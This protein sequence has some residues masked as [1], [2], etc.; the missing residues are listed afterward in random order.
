M[1]SFL[2]RAGIEYR[3]VEVPR[4]S[5][6]REA[7]ENLGIELSRI[8]KTVVLVSEQ[9][10]ALLVV[11][12][13]DRRVDQAKLARLLGCKKLRLATDSEVIE[14]TGYPP[15]GVPPVGHLRKLPVY[16][17]E[18]LLGGYYYVGG[19]DS[20]HL[21][22]IKAEDILKLAEATVLNVPKKEHT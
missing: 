12:R 11:V 5:T 15:G 9:G 10:K 6:S 16:L 17:D 7:A 14:A 21:L 1:K 18:E 2:E 4:A 3:L 8:A 19:G 22:F 13:G 20:Q